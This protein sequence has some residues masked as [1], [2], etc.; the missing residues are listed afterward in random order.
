MVKDKGE[1]EGVKPS[2]EAT[3]ISEIH[4]DTAKAREAGAKDFS[5]LRLDKKVASL[6]STKIQSRCRSHQIFGATKLD[7]IRC[8]VSRVCGFGFLLTA[9]IHTCLIGARASMWIWRFCFFL[10]SIADT[11]HTCLIAVGARLGIWRLCFFFSSIAGTIHTCSIAAR[12]R[13]R[14]YRSRGLLSYS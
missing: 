14:T 2:T 6:P 11:I 9:A 3:D 7:S 8:R 12:I 13:L 5:P 10:S 1:G 4:N